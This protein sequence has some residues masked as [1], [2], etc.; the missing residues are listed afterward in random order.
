[1]PMPL[2]LEMKTCLKR[3]AGKKSIFGWRK[4]VTVEDA[5]RRKWNQNLVVV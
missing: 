1:M 5:I 3:P 4:C 2:N